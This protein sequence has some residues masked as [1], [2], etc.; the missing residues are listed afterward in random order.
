MTVMA[1]KRGSLQFHPGPKRFSLVQGWAQS[2]PA[3][4]LAD[5]SSIATPVVGPN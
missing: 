3:L 2:T 5:P 1:V 4:E